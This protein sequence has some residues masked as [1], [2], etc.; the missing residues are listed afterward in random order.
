MLA[1]L[2]D[3]HEHRIADVRDRLAEQFALTPDEL[4]LELPSGRAKLFMNRVG[5]ATTY[6]YQ[7]GLLSRPRR[8]VYQITARGRDVLARHP[9]RVD[10]RV[11]SEFDELQEFRGRRE[12]SEVKTEPTV[13]PEAADSTRTPEEEIDVAVGLL[14]S[15]L[16]TELLDRILEQS[17]SFFEQ[18]VLDV[19]RAMGYGSTH[20]GAVQRLGQSGDGGVDGVIREDELGLDLIYVQ[21]KRWQAPVGRPE[22]Q[23]FFGAL[24]GKR[25]NK[26]VFITTSSYT[27]E[28][29]EFADSVTP[30]VI[31]VDGRELARLMIEYGVGV[32]TIKVYEIKRSD[33]DYFT[34]DGNSA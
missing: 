29:V 33:T 30:R 19:L 31:L 2:D 18:L 7:C 17:P 6:L 12:I 20:E 5:W 24:H 32:T 4:E 23:R 9:D 13:L 25:A 11:L 22:I 16:A 27:A 10:L 3:G 34:T 8:S 26:G 21:A 14:R 28:A 1:V 15:A